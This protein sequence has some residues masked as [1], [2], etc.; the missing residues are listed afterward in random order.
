[1][2]HHVSV[3]RF[4][5]KNGE[6]VL[7]VMMISTLFPSNADEEF[8]ASVEPRPGNAEWDVAPLVTLD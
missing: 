3:P 4:V 6:C 8:I 2:Y 1:M 5:E 7:R